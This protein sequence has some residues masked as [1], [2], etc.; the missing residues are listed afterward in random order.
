MR[1]IFH[2]F[3][4]EPSAGNDAYSRELARSLE[5]SEERRK[6]YERYLKG[7]KASANVGY[8]P[9]RADIENVSR[10][11]FR[12]TM[13]QVSDYDK[14]KRAGD[15]SMEDFAQ[16][17]DEQYGLVE[18]KLNGIGEPL[19]QGD[20][21][22][23]MIEYARAKNIWVRVITNASL[24]HLRDNYKKLVDSDVNEIQISIDGSDKETFEKIRRGSRFERVVENCKLINDY[25]KT[26]GV[27]IT[28]MWTVVQS[29]NV[30]QLSD[31]V[32]LAARVGFT[33]QV[34]CFDFTDWGQS[35]WR[36][37]N[38]E[39]FVGDSLSSTDYMALVQQGEA[40]G[41]RVRFW[42]VGT[43]FSSDSPEQLCPW[44]FA[45]AFIS[46]D[47]RTVPCCMIGNPD[48]Y[49]IGQGKS[50]SQAW[51]SAEYVAF[52]QSHLNG[53]VPQVCLGCYED[54]PSL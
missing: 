3:R 13:C 36:E 47:L 24:L 19:M 6:N 22:F 43:K 33:I 1:D 18:I 27:I 32:Q 26:K 8:L 34:F 16:L 46:S 41:V 42:K 40:R 50:F 5:Y 23:E 21:F 38:D 2:D 4:P 31:L 11:N 10:C 15:M 51:N 20:Q 44:P 12:C 35:I 7:D 53:D 45:R 17:I 49:E 29:A 30:H 37:R 39:V 9:I 28:K 25:A 54:V 52:R 14:G 48:T